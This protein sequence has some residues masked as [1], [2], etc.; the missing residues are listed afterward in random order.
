MTGPRQNATARGTSEAA[1]RMRRTVAKRE[2]NSRACVN[3]RLTEEEFSTE[4]E[5]GT[6]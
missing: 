2:Y 5:F 1:S 4:E 3:P 6:R